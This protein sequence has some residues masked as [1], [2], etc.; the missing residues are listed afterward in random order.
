[1]SCS[2]LSDWNTVLAIIGGVAVAYAI[3]RAFIAWV[4]WDQRT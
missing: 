2:E 1:M 4:K 3:A